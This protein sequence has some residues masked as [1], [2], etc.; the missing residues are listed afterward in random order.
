[1]NFKDFIW[2]SFKEAFQP[3]AAITGGGFALARIY[4]MASGI[5]LF[6]RKPAL[7]KAQVCREL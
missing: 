1:M 4:G 6:L 7:V 3:M 5:F 2:L